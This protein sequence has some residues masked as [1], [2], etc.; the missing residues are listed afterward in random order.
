MKLK[1]A[2]ARLANGDVELIFD[3]CMYKSDYYM[4][5]DKFKAI[6]GVRIVR[7]FEDIDTTA[8]L[9]T[10]GDFEFVLVYSSDMFV[11]NY[12][13]AVK[14]ENHTKLRDLCSNFAKFV[15]K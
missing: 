6:E 3:E 10:N 14:K 12:V 4:I 13:Y 1:V 7:E 9:L 8:C 15:Y 5:Q 2:E 11:W